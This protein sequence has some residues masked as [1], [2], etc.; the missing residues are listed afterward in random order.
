MIFSWA[1]RRPSNPCA[2]VVGDGQFEFPIVGE[3]HYQR[4]LEKMTGPRTEEGCRQKCAALLL[5]EPNNPY[6]RHAV[7]VLI[8]GIRVG[9]LSRDVCAEFLDALS[10]ADYSRAACEAVIVGGWRRRGQEDGFYGVRLNAC[11]LFILKEASGH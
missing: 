3:S 9:Y 8:H 1:K 4:E 7:A 11:L 6:D 10:R 2:V 5:P